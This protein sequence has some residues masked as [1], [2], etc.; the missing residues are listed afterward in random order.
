[1][2]GLAIPQVFRS[3]RSVQLSYELPHRIYEAKTYPILSPNGSTII[4]YGH[5]NGVR[6]VWRGGKPFKQAIES[7]DE[8]I[9]NSNGT[10]HDV[11]MILDSDDEGQQSPTPA[12]EEE[13]EFEDAEDA[14]VDSSYVV[15]FLDLFFGTS[16]LHLAIPT[17]PITSYKGASNLN[18]E[19]LSQNIVFAIVCGDRCTRLVTLPLTPPS[20]ARKLRQDLLHTTTS[21]KAGDGKWGETVAVLQGHRTI[22]DGAALTFIPQLMHKSLVPEREKKSIAHT[23]QWNVMLASYSQEISGL[24]LVYNI[25]VESIMREKL[26]QLPPL[27]TQYLSSPAASISFKPLSQ[28]STRSAH[29]LVAHKSGTVRIYDPLPSYGAG[30]ATQS[31]GTSKG[32]WLL[33]L[34]PGFSSDTGDSIDVSAANYYRKRVLDAKWILSGKAILVL[35]A[36]GEW[37]IWDVE[38]PGAGHSKHGPSKNIGIHGRAFT[39]FAVSGFLEGAITKSSS[40][41]VQQNKNASKFAPMTPGTRRSAEPSLFNNRSSQS[42]I[43][44][45]QLVVTRLA[46]P[47]LA[48]QGTECVILWFEESYAVIPNLWSFWDTQVRKSEGGSS[49]NLFGAGASAV[50]RIMRLE[51]INLQGERR[52]CVDH[53][54]K[55]PSLPPSKNAVPLDVL[56]TGEH[57]FVIASDTRGDVLSS[58]F[59]AEET[60]Q[61]AICAGGELDVSSIDQALSRMENGSNTGTG[62]V[63]RGVSF[64]R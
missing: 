15:Q 44:R 12:L 8:K 49:G 35:L 19:I 59:E 60:S 52:C 50:T 25:P 23:T 64:L 4:I 63:R 53:F 46:S 28:P 48:I 26:S 47:S 43:T 14:S 41:R 56:V 3:Q 32:V 51:S 36:D 5:E 17:I 11:I 62:I 61:L 38:G 31:N 9:S 55:D 22:A 10:S 21:C 57:R 34:Y 30:S 13:P 42:G 7:E 27:Q 6:L 58:R 18:P 37:G 54:P 39:P 40:S 2:A 16:G 20:P 45:G 29:I 1:M 33:S 24:L